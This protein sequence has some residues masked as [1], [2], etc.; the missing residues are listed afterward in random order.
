MKYENRA[1]VEQQQPSED[2]DA[3]SDLRQYPIQLRDV[4][5]AR[6]EAERRPRAEGDPADPQLEI[7][8]SRPAESGGANGFNARIRVD[9]QVP[10]AND[11]IAIVGLTV[12]GHFHS[13]DPISPQLLMEFAGRTPLVM[14]WPYARGYFSDLGRMLGTGLP[15]LPTLDA[16]APTS[17]NAATSQGGE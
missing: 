9:G 13:D 8:I 2:A 7:N 16:M 14:L 17:N 5:C 4:Y 1:S 10:L 12:Q 3:Q 11:E 6:S 15:P